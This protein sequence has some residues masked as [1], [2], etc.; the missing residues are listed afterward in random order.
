MALTEDRISGVD[1][2]PTGATPMRVRKRNGDLEP[3]DVNKIVKAVERCAL[4][5][6]L[7]ALTNRVAHIHIRGRR[8]HSL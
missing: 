5:C 6:A 3:V 8:N 2:E 1:A 4:P 7:S